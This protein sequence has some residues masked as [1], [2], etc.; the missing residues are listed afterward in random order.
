MLDGLP[1]LAPANGQCGHQPAPDAPS[2]PVSDGGAPPDQT[3]GRTA[4]GRFAKGNKCGLGNPFARRL[5]K[6]RTAALDAATEEDV[7]AIF[8]KLYQLAMIGD[9]AAAKVYL[10][11][12][13][14]K[15]RPAVDPDRLDL[16]EV[17]L[18]LEAP[19]DSQ[20]RALQLDRFSPSLASAV[21]D[22]CSPATAEEFGQRLREQLEE[23]E[24]KRIDAAFSGFASGSRRAEHQ[25]E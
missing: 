22:A 8:K 9:V 19:D 12:M 21:A 25:R 13:I 1:T 4:T 7:V 24:E 6:L 11:Y 10:D 23:L 5:G 16:D 2:A 14:G 17:A 18:W 15:P 20:M 3:T